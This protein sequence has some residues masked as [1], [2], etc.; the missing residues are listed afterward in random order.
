MNKFQVMAII[1]WVICVSVPCFVCYALK[2]GWITT[3]HDHG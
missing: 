2:R 3:D 1:V